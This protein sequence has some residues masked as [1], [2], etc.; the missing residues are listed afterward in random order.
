LDQNSFEGSVPTEIG[1]LVNLQHLNLADNRFTGTLPTEINEL[2]SLKFFAI[3]RNSVD[4]NLTDIEVCRSSCCSDARGDCVCV[5]GA[6]PC[7]L[8][9]PSPTGVMPTG[10]PPDTNVAGSSAVVLTGSAPADTSVAS[11]TSKPESR[12][13]SF[14]GSPANTAS[15][16]GNV[17]S[18]SHLSTGPSQSPSSLSLASSA[19]SSTQVIAGAVG[20]S[21]GML[22]LIV[23]IIFLF[24][25]KRVPKQAPSPPMPN[26]TTPP[27]TYHGDYGPVSSIYDKV[28]I[29]NEYDAP[30]S[31]LV[32]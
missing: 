18:H 28:T 32:F 4:G 10:S 7:N 13:F 22:F 8:N 16:E 12:S 23:A 6:G 20:G 17:P 14:T 15:D 5:T 24:R 30:D 1:S 31:T 19:D 25:R 2:N 9:M 21:A 11:S 29:P 26:E 3:A 27:P